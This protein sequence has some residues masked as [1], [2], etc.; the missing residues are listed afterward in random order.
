MLTIPPDSLLDGTVQFETQR[1]YLRA[2]AYRMLGSRAE[3]EDVVQDCWLRWNNVDLETVRDVRTY[4]CQTASNLCLD[5]LQSARQRREHYV[6]VW[7]P[8][9]LID[10]ALEYCPGPEVATEYAQEVGMAFMLALERLSALERAAFILHDVFDIDFEEVAS[11]LGRSSDACRQL[12]ARAR[13][14][15]KREAVRSQM[16]VAQRDRLLRAFGWALQRGDIDTL[17]G[18]LT[19]DAEMLSDGGGVT[20]AVPKVLQGGLR[21]AKA[22]IGFTRS[23]SPLQVEVRSVWVNGLPGAVIFDRKTGAAIQTLALHIDEQADIA[24]V[25]IVRNPNK[26]THLHRSR[27]A[28]MS[29]GGPINILGNIVLGAYWLGAW[30][31]RKFL[32]PRS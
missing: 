5:R 12:A 3:A 18:M 26:L 15:V 32:R 30:S 4:L 13:A 1:R 14:H 7:L 24:A 27:G 16:D 29:R 23:Y 10:E 17:A 9:P 31:I 21:V 19:A 25:Y 28:S 8:E 2:L 6:G 20:T 11:R 22:L